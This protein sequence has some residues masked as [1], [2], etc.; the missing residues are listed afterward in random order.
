MQK[1]ENV[2]KHPDVIVAVSLPEITSNLLLL[3]IPQ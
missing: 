3:F 1:V 2:Y